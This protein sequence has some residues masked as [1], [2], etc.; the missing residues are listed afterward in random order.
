MEKII[1]A[2]PMMIHG[3]KSKKDAVLDSLR[4]AIATGIFKPG[5]RLVID[6]VAAQFGVS[7]IPIREALQQLQA[8]GFV[9]LQPYVGA[10]VTP[11]EPGLIDEIFDLLESLELTSGRG[12]CRRMGAAD[13]AV[14]E[15]LLRELD[16]LEKAHDAWSMANIRLH[17][18]IC[19]CAQMPLTKGMLVK[20]LD[21]WNRLRRVYLDDVFRHRV[22]A[23]QQEHWDMFHAMKAGH[24][25][26]LERVVREHNRAA[27][28]AYV[29]HFQ[30]ALKQVPAST[31]VTRRASA[32]KPSLIPSAASKT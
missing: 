12:A 22:H 11:I 30:H 32:G 26:K 9:T 31:K 7:A 24:L 1:G 10:T 6:E 8:E 17:E 27:H 19:D 13:F 16:G 2:R 14:M 18:F 21:H 5:E 3:F 23:A 4:S 20:V 28:D 29:A 15:T 25:K